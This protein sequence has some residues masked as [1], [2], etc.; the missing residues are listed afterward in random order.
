MTG[1]KGRRVKSLPGVV[2]D[3]DPVIRSHMEMRLRYIEE[4]ACGSQVSGTGAPGQEEATKGILRSLGGDWEADA[5]AI[6]ECHRAEVMEWWQDF[7]E[8]QLLIDLY[9]RASRRR[10]GCGSRD[11]RRRPSHE[12]GLPV[13][14]ALLADIAD[15]GR[16]DSEWEFAA[17][18]K[19]MAALLL[20]PLGVCSRSGLRQ[21]IKRS[22]SSRI[23]FDALGL[24]WEVQDSRGEGISRPLLRWR[25]EVVGGCRRRPAKKP[26]PSHRPVNPAKLLHDVQ[27]QFTIEV[28]RRVGIP[29]RGSVSGCLIASEALGCRGPSEE[30][31]KRIWREYKGSF[32]LVMRKYWKATAKRAGLSQYQTTA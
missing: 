20:P 13:A 18:S 10:A 7:P 21:Y 28:L 12:E 23:H 4:V 3:V 14:R 15:A 11:S 24:I 30:T 6:V 19:M 31:V 32:A 29:P 26:V 1:R 9:R 17:V 27:I 5:E 8:R 25:Q 2:A 22:R 16:L